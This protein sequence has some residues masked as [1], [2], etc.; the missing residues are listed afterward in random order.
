MIAREYTKRIDVYNVTV[1]SDG[2]AGKIASE[3]LEFS[4]WAKIETNGVGYK[5]KDLGLQE[6]N[7][8]VLFRVRFR[9]DFDYTG[10]TMSLYYK[11]QRYIILA[12][13]NVD[14]KSLELDIFCSKENK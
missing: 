9:K 4:S 10:R 11:S 5:A 3:D 8:P 14:E 1:A 2:F 7:D 13:R 12:I 6:F